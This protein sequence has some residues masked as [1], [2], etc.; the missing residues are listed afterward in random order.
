MP[1]A[2]AEDLH[3]WRRYIVGTE[4]KK[5]RQQGK[6]YQATTANLNQQVIEAKWKLEDKKVNQRTTV[7]LSVGT[8][9]E[10]LRRLEDTVPVVDKKLGSLQGKLDDFVRKGLDA[11]DTTDSHRDCNEESSRIMIWAG[12]QAS[13][14]LYSATLSHRAVWLSACHSRYLGFSLP[15]G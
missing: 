4:R 14:F 12:M 10:K 2:T 13:N 1:F 5:I 11:S 9:K 8:L 6:T 3:K 7:R 15:G